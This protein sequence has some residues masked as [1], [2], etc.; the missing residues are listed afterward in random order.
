MNVGKTTDVGTATTTSTGKTGRILVNIV[1]TLTTWTAGTTVGLTHVRK[2]DGAIGDLVMSAGKMLSGHVK[3]NAPQLKSVMTVFGTSTGTLGRIHARVAT[4]IVEIA[5]DAGRMETTN[6]VENSVTEIHVTIAG[7]PKWLLRKM[8][9]SRLRSKKMIMIVTG[10]VVMNAPHQTNVTHVMKTSTGTIGK[11]LA[12]IAIGTVNIPVK[13]AGST[14]IP[15]EMFVI[16]KHLMIAGTILKCLAR[17]SVGN[18]TNVGS[19]TT[20][21]TGKIGRI[22]VNTAGER[23][24]NVV[25]T[26]AGSTH[27][28][29]KVGAGGKPVTT[30]GKM[31]GITD[32]A[33]SC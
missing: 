24:M 14:T 19:A 9:G 31:S 3:M 30:V 16:R 27:V 8:I 4:G 11:I 21:L 5:K 2:K 33:L 22:P 29:K 28:L 17:M 18:L 12:W 10:T 1:T 26:T 32:E 20:T 7:T 15:V 25:G 6:L 13:I 23:T